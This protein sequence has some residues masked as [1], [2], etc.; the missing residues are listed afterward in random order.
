MPRVL[1]WVE[2]CKKCIAWPLI[3]E[4]C[5]VKR[6]KVNEKFKIRHNEE[7]CDELYM[8]LEWRRQGI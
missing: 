5:L 8:Y 3:R 2:R 4:M 7:L 6:S 1:K